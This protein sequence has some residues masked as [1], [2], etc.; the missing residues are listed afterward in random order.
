MGTDCKKETQSDGNMN[1]IATQP[2][3]NL[4]YYAARIGAQNA[5]LGSGWAAFRA[6]TQGGY[7]LVSVIGINGRFLQ[8]GRLSPLPL[9][10]LL[11]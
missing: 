4:T 11:P 6:K 1:S 5:N 2:R 7:A 10:E 3:V 9:A 8:N